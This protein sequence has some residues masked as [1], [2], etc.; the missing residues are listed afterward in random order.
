[1]VIASASSDAR[2][3]RTREDYRHFR[4]ASIDLLGRMPTPAE[5][6]AFER[7]GFDAD[8]WLDQ[9]LGGAAYAQR[10]TRIYM[11]LLR[12][13]PGVAVQFAPDPTALYRQQ[14]MGP[15]GKLLHV[16]FRARQRRARDETDGEFCFTPEETGLHVE[17]RQPP[18]P[19]ETAIP[20]SKALLDKYTVVVKPWWLYR[21]YLQLA[22]S[23]RYKAGWDDPDPAYQPVDTLL[24]EPDGS[25][26]VEV[27]LCREEAQASETGHI[28]ATG[29]VRPAPGTLPPFGRKRP[30]PLD[31]P[32]ARDHKGESIRCQSKLGLESS[33]DCGCGTGLEHCLPIDSTVLGGGAFMFPNHVP[34]GLG[35]P[36][37]DARQ[38]A[39]RWYPFWWSQE[40]THFFEYLFSG[41]RDF[42]E[43]LT[44]HYSVI[45]GPLAQFYRTIQPSNCCDKEASFGMQSEIEPL[46]DPKRVPI[47]L[48]PH[49]VA[50]WKVIDDRGDR[51]SGLLTMPIFLEK[52]ASGRARGAA[53]YNAFLCKSFV[54][55]DVQLEPSTEP[56]LMVRPGCSTCHAAL[57]PLAAY[58]ARVEAGSLVYLPSPQFPVANDK[59]KKKADG[60][61]PGG[62]ENFYDPAFSDVHAG[63]LRGAYGSP[64]HADG[65]PALAGKDLTALPDFASCAVQRVA[66][67]FFG[68][69][70][71]HDDAALVQSL[72][73]VFVSKGYRMRPLVRALMKSSAYRDANNV[74]S[75]GS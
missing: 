9:H 60:R 41:D 6:A 42:R 55:D 53:L 23:K 13:E 16:Y 70:I 31:T 59:C 51:A 4:A 37:D 54:A 12:L 58:F 20:V 74:R 24:K 39:A 36:I 73:E 1:L 56:N 26:T 48:F 19:G 69:P 57:E 32:Y 65:G 14:I 61:L 25:A 29:R 7:P 47:E 8:A 10:L 2:A 63:T 67:S 45:N 28:Y 66:A 75:G 5:L 15:D 71:T 72:T 52:F 68:R 33:I 21:D 27:R 38:Q 40:A 30:L 35:A 50:S 64:Q 11:D 44:A 43:V 22:P 18:R 49:D 17:A 3:S 34:L 46:F 62:C